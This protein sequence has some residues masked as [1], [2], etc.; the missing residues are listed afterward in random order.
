MKKLAL[1]LL[2]SV[3]MVMALTGT[4][5]GQDQW[6]DISTLGLSF[7]LPADW[8]M[9]DE[10]LGMTEKEEVW[11]K[12]EE[13]QPNYAMIL[14]RG[15]AV[16]MYLE[17]IVE[18]TPEEF[19]DYLFADETIEFLGHEARSVFLFNPFEEAYFRM[20][21]VKNLAETNE[22][23]LLYIFALE[24]LYEEFQPVLEKILASF[25]LQN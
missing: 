8:E 7:A 5:I 18:E 3:F 25:S 2:F 16:A 10:E 15:E 23:I 20:I 24:P 6:Q 22:D 4:S 17:G 13:V 11:F 14:L 21:A 9:L 12:G 1:I 19:K